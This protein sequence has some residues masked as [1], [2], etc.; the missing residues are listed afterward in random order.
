M[1]Q[2]FQNRTGVYEYKCSKKAPWEEI[3]GLDNG[4]RYWDPKTTSQLVQQ[5][6]ASFP[7][8]VQAIVRI[9]NFIRIPNPIPDLIDVEDILKIMGFDKFNKTEVESPLLLAPECYIRYIMHK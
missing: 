1:K 8:E 6:L 4:F 5:Q 9:Q 3:T 7:R 2:F